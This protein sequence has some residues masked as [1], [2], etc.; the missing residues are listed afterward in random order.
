MRVTSQRLNRKKHYAP[1][2]VA[3]GDENLVVREGAWKGIWNAEH[4]TFELYDLATDPGERSDLSGSEPER[5]RAMRELAQRERAAFASAAR[6]P[7][8]TELEPLTAEQEDMLRKL[9]YLSE[10]D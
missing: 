9:G 2:K 3:R 6:T 5:V 4:D 8:A 1:F 10:D 7:V